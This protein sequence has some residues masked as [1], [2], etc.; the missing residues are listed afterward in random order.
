VI[1]LEAGGALAD[2][3]VGLEYLRINSLMPSLNGSMLN[4]ASDA[5]LPGAKKITF[6][7]ESI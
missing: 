5:S 4:W 3:E 6:A 7:S 2:R 1:N